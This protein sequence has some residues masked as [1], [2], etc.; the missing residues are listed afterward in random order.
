MNLTDLIVGSTEELFSNFASLG[1]TAGMPY[2]RRGTPDSEGVA[3][4]VHFS[5]QATGY[6]AIFLPA[7]LA[8]LTTRRFLFLDDEDVDPGQRDDTT[9]EL[10]NILA[11]RIKEF[12]DPRGRQIKLSL[13]H[14]CCGRDF[15]SAELPEAEKWTIPF[16][17][18]DGEFLV[19]I[20]LRML[21]KYGSQA[22][23]NHIGGVLEKRHDKSER[24]ISTS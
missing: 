14:I 23:E 7:E 13:P 5:G 4:I 18:E 16:Y 8:E 24:F 22:A 19:E 11:G 1:A 17:T 9:R 6:I 15:I 2:T 12:F 10:A 21:N 20:Q 3:G